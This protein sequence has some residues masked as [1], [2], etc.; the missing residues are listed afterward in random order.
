MAF[1]KC[2]A[3]GGNP[4]TH[5]Q[6]THLQTMQH[7]YL[8]T[9]RPAVHNTAPAQH[10]VCHPFHGYRTFSTSRTIFAWLF[11]KA[12]CS[13]TLS[14][15]IEALWRWTRPK[16]AP[17][18]RRNFPLCSFSDFFG[19]WWR[20]VE[21]MGRALLQTV[22]YLSRSAVCL[23]ACSGLSPGW[24]AGFT[25]LPA[26]SPHSERECLDL[27]VRLETIIPRTRHHFL[28]SVAPPH[29]QS[30]LFCAECP[31]IDF[32]FTIQGS[33]KPVKPSRPGLGFSPP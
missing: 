17:H 14:G 4:H 9:R 26:L 3:R 22:S 29:L 8:K 30:P 2:Y 23:Q 28:V 21:G 33:F 16:N 32:R 6:H 20:G 7:M 1:N 25:G 27:G 13:E 15:F 31:R 10:S 12:E 5:T 19:R 24:V 18:S 11:Q